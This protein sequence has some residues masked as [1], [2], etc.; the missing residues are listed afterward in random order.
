MSSTLNGQSST[1]ESPP[2]VVENPPDK[3]WIRL[4]P[5]AA[6][7]ILWADLIRQL[8]YQWKTN[9]QYAYGWFVPF[10]AL[11]LLWK[12]YAKR[13]APRPVNSPRWMVVLLATVA[14][15]FLPVRVVHEINQDWPVFSWPLALAVVV[16]SL[17][18][19]FLTGGWRWFRYFAFP[20]CFILVAVK[21]PYRIEEG[22]IH[23]LMRSVV[24]LTVKVLGWIDVMAF[25]H[26]N[27]IELSTGMVGIDEACSGIRSF[28]A[29]LMG[30]LFLGEFYW[31]RWPQR[32]GLLSG[33]IVL[34]FCLNA[35][36]T[37]ILTWQASES[38]VEALEKWHD[39]AG[40][41]IFFVCFGSLSLMAAW[42][43]KTT[44]TPDLRRP[45]SDLLPLTLGL[46][47]LFTCALSF[48]IAFVLIGNE[49]WYRSHGTKPAEAVHWWFNSPT[50]LASFRVVAVPESARKLL[51]YDLGTATSW[52]EPDGTQWFAYCFRW[53]PGD[54]TARMSALGHRPEYCLTGSGHELKAERGT[55][56]FPAHGLE[57][58]FSTYTFD[59]SQRPLHVFFCLWED[60]AEKQ[61]GFGRSK[62]LDRLRSVL[63][64]RRGLGQ[65]TFEIVVGGYR[66]LEAAERAFQERLPSLIQI[67]SGGQERMRARIAG[68]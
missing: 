25:Q 35:V 9:E 8:S 30:A 60:E 67:E 39:P 33:G 53:R 6:F 41:A 49:L 5:F 1:W 13:P 27:V 66:T 4:L 7:G 38:G 21:W 55:K 15:V 54:P 18:A 45:T 61:I 10:F 14:F 40:L 52:E 57:L 22:L 56:Y 16:M 48:W 20:L 2:F 3:I 31:L 44:A 65:Q 32:L 58:P 59:D 19:V 50:N 26:G 23:G 17:Y 36:R 12:R 28:Q 63:A 11:G 62:Y 64:G 51:K 34:A 37:L 68:K 43:R 46:P 47:R 24:G 42:L 29:T